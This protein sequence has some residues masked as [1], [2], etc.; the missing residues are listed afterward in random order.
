MIDRAIWGT[1]ERTE[2][3]SEGEPL[4][5]VGGRAALILFALIAF[6]MATDLTIDHQRGE[7]LAGQ[8]F[9][10]VIFATALAG[11]AFHAW[12]LAVA[13]R[14]SARL[15][16]ELAEA[17]A[18]ARLWSE[19]ARGAPGPRRGDRSAIRPLGSDAGRARR[20]AAP[21]QGPA[22]QGHRRASP[23]QRANRPPAGARRVPQVRPRRPERSGGVLPRRSPA[24]DPGGG[25]SRP[26]SGRPPT[27]T[28]EVRH[29]SYRHPSPPT[30]H[31]PPP[32]IISLPI[33]N[34]RIT[35]EGCYFLLFC[36][37]R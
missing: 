3:A 9:E 6:L 22:A 13:E 29:L 11:I 25:P 36:R 7:S 2:R 24:A 16:R 18:E 12:Q 35:C 10:L 20:R 17:R 14:R 37:P 19:E 23:H 5:L 26:R 33:T 31:H 34:G 30:R 27:L 1:V 15:D 4:Q 28:P 8:S 32:P 21:A